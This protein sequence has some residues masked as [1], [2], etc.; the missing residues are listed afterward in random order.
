[1]ID[2]LKY[3]VA[4]NN[5]SKFGPIRFKRIRKYFSNLENAFKANLT[6]LMQAG[7]EEKVAGEFIIARSSIN[8]DDLMEKIAKEN[9]EVVTIEDKH[10]PKLLKEIY[11]Q[12]PLLYY[13]GK[14]T[15]ADE[16]AL[17]VVGSR[18]YSSYGKQVAEQLIKDLVINNLTIVSGL[19]IGIDTLAHETTLIAH[20]KTIAVLGS[21]LN[22]KNIYPT[23]NCYLA[24]KIVA[25]G[26][27]I[28]S[29][30]PLGTPPLRHHFPQRNRVI[31]GLSLGVLVIEASL[32]SGSL[33]T[34]RHALEQNRDIFAVPGNI[35]SPNS[36]GTN[37][38]IEQ[39]A[40]LVSTANDIIETLNLTQVSS[41]IN[42]K[43]IIP[44]SQ[45]EEKILTILTFEPIHVDE[46]IR[47]TKLDTATINSTLTIMEMKGVIK[48]L[49]GMQYVLTR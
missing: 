31:S 46:L 13:R 42:N 38:L 5:F 16:F 24:D 28:I 4:L 17:A 32:K 48:N 9:I 22:K 34:A 30:F 21:G 41:Y 33:I 10:Y 39:G 2:D 37:Y 3:W 20:G 45:E 19:A 49:G 14:L 18:K 15:I 43:T 29:E 11:N 25:S 7:I 44:D 26:G 47:L 36:S 12:P 1:M 40:K 23:Q 27:V 35:Y 8:P 6:D